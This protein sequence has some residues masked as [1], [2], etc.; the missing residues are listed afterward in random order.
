MPR[1]RKGLLSTRRR[2]ET[3]SRY[4]RNNAY[5]WQDPFPDVKGTSIEKMIYA[6]LV[7][8]GVRFIFQGDFKVALP[9]ANIFKTYRPDFMLPD[10][11]I[12]IDPFGAYWHNSPKAIEADSYKF[13]LFEAMGWKVVVWW[14]YE[15]ETYGL[16]ALIA[17][18]PELNVYTKSKVEYGGNPPRNRNA[19]DD[20]K[21]L[22]TLNA[23]KR[24]PYRTFVGTAR[25]KIRKPR[26][27]YVSR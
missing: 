25:R 11:K 18:V 27:T 7:L 19:V 14:D 23:R 24:K 20:L 3:D 6:R 13:A 26:T 9:Q 1:L 4:Y 12:I 17:R 5:D 16:D 21:G 10:V 15:I 8:M 2:I 22:R